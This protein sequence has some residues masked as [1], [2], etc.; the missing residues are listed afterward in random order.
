MV[1]AG[2]FHSLA[3]TDCNNV[4]A[5]GLN[6]KGQLGLGDEK[7]RSVWTHIVNLAGKRVDKVYAGG[8]HSWAI[9]SI[10]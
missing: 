9:I 7:I 3:L 8:H 4:Y 1:A 6:S 5:C 2:S 10:I